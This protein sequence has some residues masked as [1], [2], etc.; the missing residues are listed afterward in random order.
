[1]E[2]LDDDFGVFMVNA[3]YKENYAT[4][5]KSMDPTQVIDTREKKV[6]GKPIMSSPGL[7]PIANSNS[8]PREYL[9]A[10]HSLHL[11]HIYQ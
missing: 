6:F 8:L 2:V 3:R 7:D 4:V 5:A 1:M 11:R 10:S 9:P